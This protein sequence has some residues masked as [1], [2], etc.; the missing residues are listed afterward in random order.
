MR[1][2]GFLRGCVFF[3]IVLL[4]L[5]SSAFATLTSYQGRY[6]SEMDMARASWLSDLGISEPDTTIDF[7]TGFVQDEVVLD[8]VLDGGMTISSPA[9]YGYVTND[10]ADMGNSL[11]I[12]TF[13]LAIDEGDAYTFSFASPI[14][15]FAFY[16]MDNSTMT[17]GL[18]VNYSDGSSDL[19]SIPNGGSS[20]LNGIFLAMTFD[21]DVDSLYIAHVSGGDSEVGIDNLEFGTV[22]EP[23]S[24]SLLALGSLAI[25]RRRC[26]R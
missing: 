4:A 21:K 17:N 8:T 14:S 5:S 7:E 23:M 26:G 3:S 6:G 11:P 2:D 9:G 15:Y 24:L 1:R 16:I 20:G 13:A 18:Q 25:L 12:G 19:V 10:S 22:P